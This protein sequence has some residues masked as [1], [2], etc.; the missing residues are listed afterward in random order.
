MNIPISEL[1]SGMPEEFTAF[2][3]ATRNYKFEEEPQYRIIEKMFGKLLTKFGL[4]MEDKAYDWG[5][6]HQPKVKLRKNF[7]SQHYY[8][9]T[10]QYSSRQHTEQTQQP[11][12]Y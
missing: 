8:L 12:T 9:N 6:T 10:A 2:C 5:R 7:C 1:C 11:T 3:N 4:D